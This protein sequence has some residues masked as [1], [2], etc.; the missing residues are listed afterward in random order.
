MIARFRLYLPFK[1]VVTD[2]EKLT[3]IEKIESGYNIK[4]YPPLAADI[5]L[6]SLDSMS[7]IAGEDIIKQLIP[8]E[9]QVANDRVLMNSQ[10]TIQANLF[11]ID[12]IKTGLE[13]D[14]FRQKLD[15]N[16]K[17]DSYGDPPPSLA[18]KI[19]NEFLDK[20]RVIT[21]GSSIS[22]L[23]QEMSYWRLDY[24]DDNEGIL[25]R[26]EDK[27]RKRTGGYSDWH[28][29][30]INEVVWQEI[31]SLPDDF[32]IHVWDQLILDAS[33]FLPQIGAPIAL[34]NAALEA[35]IE[36]ALDILAK[37]KGVQPDLWEW[38]SNRDDD[39]LKQP[40]I[41]EKYS[42][43]LKFLTGSSLSDN[44]TLW[45]AFTMLRCAR[46]SY[47]H[48][49]TAFDIKDKAKRKPIN[50]K[51]CK[52]LIKQSMEII[53]WVEKLLPNEYQRPKIQGNTTFQVKFIVNH[54]NNPDSTGAIAK[55]I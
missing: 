51:E 16:K 32:K 43:I 54:K 3:P 37:E 24:L 39:F 7:G 8:T 11:Q 18:F 13:F 15:E 50:S 46:N 22:N 29:T 5:D 27:I 52:N 31:Q 12:F 30:G 1:F 14:R 44:E 33:S 10:P 4:I 40:S 45:Q 48:E 49:G 6:N 55:R 41:R 35:F 19:I 17:D 21:R 28:F 26:S 38:I 23:S 47:M 36:W 34:A 53:N 25:E 9:P 42:K 2:F 20:S